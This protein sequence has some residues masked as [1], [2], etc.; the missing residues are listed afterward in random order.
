MFISYDLNG[1]LNELLN[2]THIIHIH[3]TMS[4]V[5]SMNDNIPVFQQ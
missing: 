1:C 5:L 3:S 4:Y 2:F